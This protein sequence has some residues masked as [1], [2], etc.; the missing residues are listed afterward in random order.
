M[1]ETDDFHGPALALWTLEALVPSIREPVRSDSHFMQSLGLKNEVQLSLRP[2]GPSF[3]RAALLSALRQLL[4]G[5][6][7]KGSCV[8]MSGR[9]WTL[10]LETRPEDGPL[11]SITDGTKRL[12]LPDHSAF[13]PDSDSRLNG[14]QSHIESGY[15]DATSISAWREKLE[16]RALSDDELWEYLDDVLDTPQSF[17]A[18]VVASLRR[19]SIK[20]E[21]LVPSSVRYFNR[22]VGV[23]DGAD[24]IL[25]YAQGGLQAHIESLVSWSP[26]EGPWYGLLL[27][28][29]S[30][31]ASILVGLADSDVLDVVA[32]AMPDE[33]DTISKVGAIEFGLPLIGAKPEVAPMLQAI[34]TQLLGDDPETEGG[35]FSL[36]TSLITLVDGELARTRALSHCPPFWRRLAAISQASLIER[37]I[38]TA[39]VDRHAFYEWAINARTE[40]FYTQNLIDLRLEPRWHPDYA[41]PGQLKMEVLGRLLTLSKAHEGLVQGANLSALTD[42]ALQS[43]VAFPL[44]FLAGP[45]EGNIES[46]NELPAELAKDIEAR[47]TSGSIDPTSFISLVNSVLV[48]RPNTDHAAL[49]AKAIR[50]ANY[51]LR[52]AERPVGLT[53]ILNG[54]ATVAANS[55][56]GVLAAELVLLTRRAKRSAGMVLPLEE[57]ISLGLLAGAAHQEVGAWADFVGHWM[58]E[59]AFDPLEKSEAR[60]LRSRLRMLCKLAPSLW[61]TCGRALAASSAVAGE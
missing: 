49:A 55:R 15:L 33:A 22:L 23:Y 19:G 1:E 38:R 8:D 20:L 18:E 29:H 40:A 26:S 21:N 42:E 35:R 41:A 28:S 53:A 2:D 57:D 5:A 48:F 24:N 31:T 17:M 34:V 14:L 56:S 6:T 27:S 7:A 11:I 45:L 10:E 58:T 4:A 47:L 44:P 60:R 54:L 3:T 9:A 46:T 39:R 43:L 13:S 59:L 51:L 61:P 25:S 50:D 52:R 36:L 16:A 37:A 32:R 12:L 30:C